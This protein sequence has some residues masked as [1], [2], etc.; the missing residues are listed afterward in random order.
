M[1]SSRISLA[2][3]VEQLAQLVEVGDLDLDAQVR[4]GRADGLVRRHHAAGRDDVVV[5]DHRPVARLN[6]WLTPPPQRTA[7]FWR[8]R[9]PAA[10][11]GCRAPGPGALEGVDPGAVAVATPERWQAKLSAVR[12]A[13]SSPRVGPATRITTSPGRRGCRRRPGR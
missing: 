8:A 2:A 6:R 12:S 11:C 9:Q 1:L 4:V 13:V 10:S 5:L 7:Y 3:G